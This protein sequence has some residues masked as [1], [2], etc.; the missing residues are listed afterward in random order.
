M[1]YQLTVANMNVLLQQLGKE[2]QI[3][4]PKV[5]RGEGRF[6]D[7]DL[8]RYG[9]VKTIEEIESSEDFKSAVMSEAEKYHKQELQ[10][11]YNSKIEIKETGTKYDYAGAGCEEYDVLMAQKKELDERVKQLE[12]DMKAG[13]INQVTGEI[14]IPKATKTSTTA[15][16]VTINK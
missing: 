5:F 15:I 9:E 8:I 7:T 6:A 10:N 13:R 2:C 14:V 16:F 12:N 11:L 1:G 4:A 3:F